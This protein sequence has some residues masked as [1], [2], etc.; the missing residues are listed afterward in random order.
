M[1]TKTYTL[2]EI[3]TAWERY[4]DKA[5]T[6]LQAQIEGKWVTIEKLERHIAGTRARRVPVS[7]AMG[8]PKYL[9]VR[10]K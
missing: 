10:Y 9:E 3:R 7:G 4:S 5:N 8:F 6:I 2:S 1:K